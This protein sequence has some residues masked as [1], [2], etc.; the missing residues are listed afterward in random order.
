MIDYRLVVMFVVWLPWPGV[1]EGAPAGTSRPPGPPDVVF[2]HL[3]GCP[4]SGSVILRLSTRSDDP[5]CH[6]REPTAALLIFPLDP[7]R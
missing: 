3:H 1:A 5:R 7:R 4:S 6:T 2:E